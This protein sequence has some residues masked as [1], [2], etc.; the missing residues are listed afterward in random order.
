MIQRR[1][2]AFATLLALSSHLAC[3][4][5]ERSSGA[6]APHA[7]KTAAPGSS[8]AR[9]VVALTDDSINPVVAKAG[10]SVSLRP[11]AEGQSA[12]PVPEGTPRKIILNGELRLTVEAYEPARAEL[13]RLVAE[14]RGFVSAVQV[15][16][17]SERVSSAT[18]T[19]RIP[20]GRYGE[21]VA[22]ISKL[23]T[24]SHESSKADDITEQYYDLASRLS[25]AKKLEGRI[26]ELLA[27]Q[28]GKLTE[29]LQVERELAR[30][31]EEVER[32]EGKLRLWDGLTSLSTLVVHLS[33]RVSYDPARAAELG[34]ELSQDLD[35]SWRDFKRFCR[36]LLRAAVRIL[37]WL[38]V[39]LVVGFVGWWFVR[40]LR[41]RFGKQKPPPPVA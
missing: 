21:L 9:N 25:N 11:P 26:L 19:L 28:A 20:A 38:P 6:E 33:T 34:D 30:V 41:R 22:R 36:G 24:V 31:R 16:H 35:S 10:T 3:S 40:R 14:A 37:P 17:S 29:I 27:K 23:G 7:S 5:K 32:F 1:A 15:S 4:K 18:L 8:V 12:G 39:W 13:E 2:L